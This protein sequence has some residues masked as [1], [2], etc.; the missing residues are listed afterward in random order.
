MVFGQEAGVAH[1]AKTFSTLS[2]F[3]QGTTRT[4][5]V[6]ENGTRHPGPI[7]AGSTLWLR[8]TWHFDG[9]AQWS[10]SLDGLRFVDIGDPYQ[11]TWA[12]YRGDRIGLFTTNS[13]STGFVDIRTFDFTVR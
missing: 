13:A 8:S 1:F 7:V 6:N 2:V 10:Y 9:L 4:L 5:T 11:L 12:H 3:Q